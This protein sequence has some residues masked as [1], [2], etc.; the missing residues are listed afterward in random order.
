MMPLALR[1]PAVRTRQFA[2]ATA[3]VVALEFALMAPMMVLLL[4]GTFDVSNAIIA[5]SRLTAAAQQIVE[6]ATAT[7]SQ[8]NLNQLTETQAYQATTAPFALLPTLLSEVPTGG[9]LPPGYLNNPGANFSITLSGVQFLGQ[10]AGC[11]TN[12]TSY[13]TA[14]TAWSMANRLGT[15]SVRLCGTLTGVGN[16]TSPSMTTMPIG[17]FG[18]TGVLVADIA[19]TFVPTFSSVIT[20]PIQM[21]RTA[22]LSPR[23]GTAITFSPSASPSNY[24]ISCQPP[25]Q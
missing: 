1:I 13:T 25:A 11:T 6:I 2:R 20:G 22:Y 8:A 14:Y 19:Y 9:A 3:G 16:T 18:P 23:S 17:A 12:C 21:R 4:I 5:S 24:S 7:A 15:K 10:P